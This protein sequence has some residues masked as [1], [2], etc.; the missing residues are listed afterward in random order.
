MASGSEFIVEATVLRS[1][2]AWDAA[3]RFIWTHY[4]LSVIEC[5]KAPVASDRTIV[6]S[7]PGG[8]ADGVTMLAEDATTYA[9]GEK[10]G[11]LSL[12]NARRIPASGRLW[13]GKVYGHTS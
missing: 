6:V 12:A 5:L 10:S 11:G 8:T 7:E 3:H 4:E 9:L 1:W 13:P 2:A